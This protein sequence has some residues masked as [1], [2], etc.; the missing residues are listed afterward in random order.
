MAGEIGLALAG[1]GIGL[2]LRHGIDWDHI[3]A[4]SDVTASQQSRVRSVAMG[5]LYAAGHAAVVIA[6]GL[7]AIWA[8]S[9][10]PDSLDPLM[11]ALVGLT[12]VLL[13][14]WILWSLVKNRGRLVLRSRWM[15]LADSVRSGYRRLRPRPPR[16]EVSAGAVAEAVE[17]PRQRRYGATASTTVGVIHGIG[18]E[19]GTQALLLA[20]A[21][22]ATSAAAGSFLLVAFAI[23]LVA[24]NLLITVASTFGFAAGVRSS[25][26]VTT[27]FGVSIA[28]FS[29]VIGSLFLFRKADMLPGFLA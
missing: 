14:V 19:T 26:L 11:D 13:G 22:G 8:G 2:G 20:S 4:I 25:R 16:T 15:L 17:S 3:A 10:L 6:L 29:L 1:M 18:A 12:L 27:V 21:A 7:L 24:S 5:T 28:A 23:G 9:T